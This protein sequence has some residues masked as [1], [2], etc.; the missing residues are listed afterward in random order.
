MDTLADNL[1]SLLNTSALPLTR[2]NVKSSSVRQIKVGPLRRMQLN[3]L[4]VIMIFDF[5]AIDA[6]APFKMSIFD[7]GN[8]RLSIPTGCYNNFEFPIQTLK[9]VHCG[10]ML[11]KLACIGTLTQFLFRVFLVTEVLAQH[12][13]RFVLW[14]L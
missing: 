10:K 11:D 13:Y 2:E 4:I 5:S 8:H 14:F 12:Y 7:I 3:G 6:Y 9:S 1:V